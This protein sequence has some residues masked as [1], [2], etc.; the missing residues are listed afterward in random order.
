M[1][2]KK[3]I[4]FH[5]GNTKRVQ[6]SLFSEKKKTNSLRCTHFVLSLSKGTEL[7]EICICMYNQQQPQKIYRE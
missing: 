2:L 5:V 1:V 4:I 6:L 3:A 7:F